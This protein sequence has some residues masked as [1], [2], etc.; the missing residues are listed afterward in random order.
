MKTDSE[1][2]APPSSFSLWMEEE[3]R[4]FVKAQYPEATIAEVKRR[5]V[6]VWTG[7]KAGTKL[8]FM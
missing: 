5:C 6:Q 3:G 4:A 7:L 1:S 2:G 8:I